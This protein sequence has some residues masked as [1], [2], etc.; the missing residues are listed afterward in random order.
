VTD[1]PIS[2]WSIVY[3]QK[4]FNVHHDI[5]DILVNISLVQ[6]DVIITRQYMY[7]SADNMFASDV[8][9]FICDIMDVT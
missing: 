7:C 4:L 5:K 8:E 2:Y 1:H 9:V 6:K 3:F